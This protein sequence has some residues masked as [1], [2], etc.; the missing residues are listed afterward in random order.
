METEDVLV[1]TFLFM[2]ILVCI[3]DFPDFFIPLCLGLMAAYLIGK[4][5]AK[6]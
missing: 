1:Y 2:P 3:K 6:K 4:K 5:G